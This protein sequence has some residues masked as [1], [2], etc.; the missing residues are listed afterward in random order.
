MDTEEQKSVLSPSFD[1]IDDTQSEIRVWIGSH[2]H[3]FVSQPR[4]VIF[5]ITKDVNLG[6]QIYFLSCP[7]ILRESL[8]IK[9]I[10]YDGTNIFFYNNSIT[11]PPYPNY[12]TII[13]FDSSPHH[14]NY[15]MK[16][17]L[18]MHGING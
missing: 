15:D 8:K 9:N 3:F 10:L 7:N 4:L 14:K 6:Y 11:L 17:K 2:W 5:A 16:S 1:V 13:F 18:F 12:D